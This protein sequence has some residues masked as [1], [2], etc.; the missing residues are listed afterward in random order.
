MLAALLTLTLAASLTRTTQAETATTPPQPAPVV[1]HPRLGTCVHFHQTGKGWDVD[2]VMPLIV[3]SGVSWIRDEINWS[4]LEKEKG[5]YAIPE[6]DARWIE[7]AHKAGLKIMLL[8]NTRGNK[9]YENTYD[10]GAYARAAAWLARELDGKIHAIEV[11][12][13]PF[14][15]KGMGT[16]FGGAW[17]GREPD[18]RTSPWV[19]HYVKLLNAAAPAIKAANPR[20]T[21]VGLGA[22][23]PV[24]FRM[25]E[26][27]IAPE[28]DAIADHP[29][30]R[31]VI[32]ELVLFAA[33]EG[34][35]K[36]DGVATADKR[37]AYASQVRMY[38]ERSARFNGPKQFWI[39]ETGFTT[40]PGVDRQ[41]H[42]GFTEEAQARYLQR[43]IVEALGL[44]VDMIFQY[45]FKNDGRDPNRAQ[46][47]FG[48]V[49]YDLTPKPALGAVNRVAATLAGL[50]PVRE[51]RQI[52]V[53]IFPHAERIDEWP[54][55]W[56]GT[57]IAAPGAIPVHHFADKTGAPAIALWSA[58]RA[59][60]DQHPRHAD[61]EFVTAPDGNSG[62]GFGTLKVHDL[63]TGKTRIV[64][65]RQKNATTWILD[66][67]VVPDAPV[68][69][70][71]VPGPSGLAAASTP[72]QT[73]AP[74]VRDVSLP[75]SGRGWKFNPGREFAGAAGKLT[76]AEQ[77][78]TEMLVVEYDFSGGGR[79]VSADTSV[80]IGTDIGE[81][82]FAAKSGNALTL[83][84]R[85]IDSTGQTFQVKK[86][87]DREDAWQLFRV[88][89]ADV[90]GQSWGGAN[91]KKIHF[92]IR[93]VRIC[94]STTGK[95]APKTGR[96]LF[97]DT[98]PSV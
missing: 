74:G 70:T 5:V 27:G 43:R 59:G 15:F 8:F 60:S 71:P 12:N 63:W 6:R 30:S 34:I 2:T 92:P 52:T 93:Q 94:I 19:Y 4:A 28:V 37:G 69:I 24:N 76:R 46:H 22:E 77:N 78:G 86:P 14:N 50:E 61:V 18:N 96:I 11:M 17:N 58:E 33:T 9:L 88:V 10:P 35:L 80:E 48:L 91:D 32:P 44:G 16:V 41:L 49:N 66:Q 36:R 65:P 84:V 73:I 42:A 7:A 83:A 29:Y 79:Y 38:R 57:R 39:T 20:L 25:L 56:D 40:Y 26:I 3:Q 53:T 55:R 98:A 47:H 75:A 13:E 23:A 81:I 67:F 95:D 89:L 85:L 31:R 87:C 1:K 45:A 90:K 21:V 51:N 97:A 68:L 62:S 64:K 54:I 72:P 82:R